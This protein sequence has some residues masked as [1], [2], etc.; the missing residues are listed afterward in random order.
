MKN[1]FKKVKTLYAGV[2][3]LKA[4]PQKPIIQTNGQIPKKVKD[5]D[6]SKPIK[7]DVKPVQPSM[8]KQNEQILQSQQT[9]IQ[10]EN[11]KEAPKIIEKSS[12][13]PKQEAAEK[14][15]KELHENAFVKIKRGENEKIIEP[16]LK[17]E[18]HKND[19]KQQNN[20]THIIMNE[21]KIVKE[22]KTEISKN[23]TTKKE[24][25]GKKENL[26]EENEAKSLDKLGDL[27]LEI[28]NS[29]MRQIKDEDLLKIIQTFKAEF[30]NE[31]NNP[32]SKKI[33]IYTQIL[34]TTLSSNPRSKNLL[35]CP[36]SLSI[37]VSI[38]ERIIKKKFDQ[39]KLQGKN[40]E[41]FLYLENE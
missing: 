33:E 34:N 14:M 29:L 6:H 5:Q 27:L 12:E 39:E 15:K 10:S 4:P 17:A 38:V 28:R 18:D 20:N 26:S 30:E 8:P 16:I 3:A 40:S 21:N 11:S 35:K 25:E 36:E 13:F 41:V 24:V 31:M 22:K 1:F 23:L 32:E 9:K 37:C 7:A 2:D 19:K